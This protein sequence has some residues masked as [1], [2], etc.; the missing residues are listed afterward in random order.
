M[1]SCREYRQAGRPSIASLLSVILLSGGFWWGAGGGLFRQMA[2][3][4]VCVGGVSALF[5]ALSLSV[6]QS[7][8]NRVFSR[9]KALKEI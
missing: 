8:A 5:A 9:G 2:L 1:V 3:G 6:S 4:V 7:V